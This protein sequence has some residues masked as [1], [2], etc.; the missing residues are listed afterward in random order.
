MLC[1]FLRGAVSEASCF[2][3]FESGGA[4]Q[5]P[6]RGDVFPLNGLL[7]LSRNEKLSRNNKRRI[8]SDGRKSSEVF[9]EKSARNIKLREGELYGEDAFFLQEGSW[10]KRN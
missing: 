7:S 4:G 9:L 6:L 8:Y 1:L 3:C 2:A 10:D 5:R